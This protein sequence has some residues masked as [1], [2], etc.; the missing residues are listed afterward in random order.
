MRTFKIR[1]DGD[2]IHLIRSVGGPQCREV[3]ECRP[4]GC[5]K[6]VGVIPKAGCLTFMAEKAQWGVPCLSHT[7]TASFDTP[8]EDGVRTVWRKVLLPSN[9]KNLYRSW[10]S[11][12]P[13]KSWHQRISSDLEFHGNQ[14]R[15]GIKESLQILNFTETIKSW[16]QRIFSNLNV[17]EIS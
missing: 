1:T 10:I 16:H 17:I 15:L 5:V 6:G 9:S 13:I 7:A 11:Q 4:P 14:S 2:G 12:K 3:G 8:L